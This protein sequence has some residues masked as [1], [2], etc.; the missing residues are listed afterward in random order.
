MSRRTRRSESMNEEVLSLIEAMHENMQRLEELTGGE[1]DAVADRLGRTFMLRGAQD[2]LR[3]SEAAKQAA[4]LNA[5]PAHIAL[6]DTQGVIISVNGQWRQFG[7]A[8]AVQGPG[9]ATGLNYLA[10]CDRARGEGSFEAHLAAKGIRSVLADDAKTFSVEYS[11]HSPTEGRWFLMTVVRL[12][13][14]L[15][16]G[17][18]VMHI[19]ITARKQAEIDLRSSENRFRSI[20]GAVSEGIFIIDP[21]TASFR[22]VNQAGA[23]MFG[24]TPDELIGLDSRAI[25]SSVPSDTESA[26][27][28]WFQTAPPMGSPQRFDWHCRARDG[29]RFLVEVSLQ[30]ATI[31]GS[32]SILAT[33]SDVTERRATEEKLRQNESRL[34]GLASNLPGVLFQRLI[35]ADGGCSFTYISDRCEEITGYTAEEWVSDRTIARRHIG[36]EHLPLFL[37]AMRQLRVTP[38][39][40]E[41]EYACTTK[42]GDEKWFQLKIQPRTFP[43]GDVLWDGLIFDISHQKRLDRQRVELENQLRQVQKIEAIGT[44][45]GGIAH[46]LN[47]TLVPILVL[48]KLALKELP[49]GSPS[50]EKLQTTL[51][52]ACRARALVAEILA[53]SRKEQP[54]TIRVDVAETVASAVRLFAATLPPNIA[55]ENRAARQLAIDADPNQLLQVLMNLGTNAAHAIGTREGRILIATDEAFMAEPAGSHPDN[56]VPGDYVR[57]LVSDDGCGM[58]S[59]TVERVFEPFFTTKPIGDGTGL[60]LSVV[61]GIIKNHRGRISVQSELGRGTTFTILLPRSEAARDDGAAAT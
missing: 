12:D 49:P 31:N 43:S 16:S 25:L 51:D 40:T 56:V 59:R 54:R 19:D 48:T 33:M 44:L 41:I 23:A 52:A 26:A 61:H 7:H 60:G 11:C 21:A 24:Y 30:P 15:L 3:L 53:F 10:I 4:I 27:S 34:Q 36:L 5:L 9:H 22:D 42:R 2:R 46:E 28:A 39:P 8:T 17:A 14:E 38:R 57:I 35:R 55:L 29:R 1:V 37:E 45:A 32:L 18:V 13:N 6:L 20:F 47:N 50:T 58:D